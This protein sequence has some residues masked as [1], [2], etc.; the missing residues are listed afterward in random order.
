MKFKFTDKRVLGMVFNLAV[1]IISYFLFA[2]VKNSIVG[3][4]LTDFGSFQQWVGSMLYLVYV[5]SLVALVM[6]IIIFLLRTF[7]S[8]IGLDEK[9]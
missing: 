5:F 3:P 9:V 6:Q 2:D 7:A 1:V 4:G 8:T